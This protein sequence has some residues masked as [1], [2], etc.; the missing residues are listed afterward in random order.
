MRGARDREHMDARGGGQRR[1][2]ARSA[3]RHLA[4]Q[5]DHLRRHIQPRRG[6]ERCVRPSHRPTTS[7]EA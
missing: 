6:R 1:D 4:G 2:R 3:E 5:Q 7:W